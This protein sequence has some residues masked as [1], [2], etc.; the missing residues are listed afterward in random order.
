MKKIFTI[1]IVLLIAAG[2]ISACIPD[3]SALS[4]SN[5]ADEDTEEV[6]V[7]PAEPTATPYPSIEDES[8]CESIDKSTYAC[9]NPTDTFGK[10]DD[11]Y[12]YFRIRN[13]PSSTFKAEWSYHNGGKISTYEMT[14]KGNGKYYFYISPNSSWKSGDAFL[15]LY[16]DGVLHKTYYFSIK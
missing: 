8:F 5:S 14:I 1:S 16:V 11:I 2:L 6:Y 12:F 9:I 10:Y 3:F 4:E 15:N 13:Y 7:A